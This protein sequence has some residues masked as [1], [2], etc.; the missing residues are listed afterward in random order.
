[1]ERLI[2]TGGGVAN[3]MDCKSIFREFDSLPVLNGAVAQLGERY[4]CTVDVGG[5][6][7]SS[8]TYAPVAQLDRATGFYPVGYVFESHRECNGIL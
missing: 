6:I 5:S 2:C 1:M 7:P 8:S 3:A 4:T